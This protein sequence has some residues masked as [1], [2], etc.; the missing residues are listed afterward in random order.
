MD[1]YCDLV[2]TC[3]AAPNGLAEYRLA[4]I[5]RMLNQFPVDGI[6]LDNNLAYA[7]CTLWKEHGHPRQVYD[8]LIE[9]HE[10]NWRRRELLRSKC[11]HAVLVSH[12]ASAPIL[13]LFAISTSN[14][15]PRATPLTRCT[16]LGLL[17]SDPQ[18]TLAGNDLPGQQG[19]GSLSRF[20]RL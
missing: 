5:Q 10:M 18:H 2:A 12:C 16:L 20:D 13:R 4:N 1:P 6:Y 9:L 8:C 19:C 7:N 11:P 15:T 14:T 3:L 17:W